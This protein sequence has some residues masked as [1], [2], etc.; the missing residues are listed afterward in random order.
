MCGGEQRTRLWGEK[1]KEK[2]RV[3]ERSHRRVMDGANIYHWLRNLRCVWQTEESARENKQELRERKRE[4]VRER[5][6]GGARATVK[7]ETSLFSSAS[8]DITR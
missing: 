3:K 1:E 6:E 8:A 7:G 2:E 4:R 5:D